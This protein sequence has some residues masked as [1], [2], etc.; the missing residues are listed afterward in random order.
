MTIIPVILSGG[1]GTRLWPLSRTS[2]PKQFIKINSDYTLFQQTLDRLRILATEFGL[3][4]QKPVVIANKDHRFLVAEQS[5]EMSMGAIIVLEPV[6]QNTAPAIAIASLMELDKNDDT[7]LLVLPS[8]HY[9]ENLSELA[10]SIKNLES[11]AK[12]GFI[13]TFGIKPIYEDTGFGYIKKGKKLNENNIFKVDKFTEKPDLNLAKQFIN[14]KEYDWNSGILLF[15][16]KVMWDE[17]KK[18]SPQTVNAAE[19]S[20]SKSSSDL[21][22]IRLDEKSYKDQ[23]AISIDYALME[24]SDK[25]VLSETVI[26]WSDVGS[27]KAIRNV[28]NS[29]DQGN[30]IEGDVYIEDVENCYLSSNGR[31]LVATGV[32]DLSIVE[33]DDAVLVSKFGSESKIKKIVE[34]LKNDKRRECDYH[35]KVYRPWGSYQTIDEGPNFQVKRIVV[36]P[37]AK[38]SL[39]MHNH[40]AEHWIVVNGTAEVTIDEKT[41]KLKENESTFI[42]L[43]AKHRLSNPS[44]EDLNLIEVQSGSY[45]GEDDIIRFD[46]IYGRK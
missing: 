37:K 40:R 1:S 6:A 33:M 31:L 38:L 32:K 19:N 21:D 15:Q 20:L 9:I 24:K 16:P 18:Y 28:S 5:R 13:G 8:D 39:Q 7:F 44:S 14:S 12:D 23:E 41:F 26:N 17:L 42:P 4:I 27:W 36:K 2:Y 46:D 30:T 3:K 22:F 43:G 35:T 29:D 45:L 10:N 11:F 34:D 25:L